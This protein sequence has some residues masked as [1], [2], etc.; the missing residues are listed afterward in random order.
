MRGLVDGI[1]DFVHE[2]QPR[3]NQFSSLGPTL[4]GSAMWINDK[5][6]LPA[7]MNIAIHSLK[8]HRLAARPLSH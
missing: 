2:R 4:L 5:S 3:W 7:S 1:D 6:T 8:T